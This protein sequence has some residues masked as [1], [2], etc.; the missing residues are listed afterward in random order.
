M[1]GIATCDSVSSVGLDVGAR[2]VSAVQLTGNESAWRVRRAVEFARPRIQCPSGEDATMAGE[3]A[4]AGSLSAAEARAIA[5]A[6]ERFGMRGRRV[7]LSMPH[8]ELVQALVA[9]PPAESGAPIDRL[10]KAELSRMVRVQPG[11]LESACWP[12]ETA[13]AAGAGGSAGGTGHEVLAVG[14]RRREVLGIVA[15]F[16]ACGWEV[17]AM[18]AAGCAIAAGVQALS[19]TS[20]P[21]RLMAD[22]GW[23]A[24]RIIAVQHGKPA[25]Q[26]ALPDLGLSRLHAQC[27]SEFGFGGVVLD[28]ALTGEASSRQVRDAAEHLASTFVDGLTREFRTSL[29][30]VEDGFIEDADDSIAVIGGGGMIESVVR[31]VGEELGVRIEAPAHE[32]EARVVVPPGSVHALG[33][34]LRFD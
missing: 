27:R 2:T 31:R 33:L 7:T 12:V 17:A 22:I 11:E 25:Y 9:T 29:G 13:P 5:D 8:D 14:C 23:S 10:A 24:T 3:A 30:Y 6:I 19:P 34:A 18:D 26:R 28:R 32:T 20:A 21:L 4:N 1:I 16:D 15:A